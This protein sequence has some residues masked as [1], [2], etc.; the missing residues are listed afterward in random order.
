MFKLDQDNDSL[1]TEFD[2]KSQFEDHD[3]IIDHSS[4][5]EIETT[6][7]HKSNTLSV[8]IVKKKGNGSKHTRETS[9]EFVP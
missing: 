9:K 5:K 4:I 3:D 1:Q 7:I 6:I 8:P 2:D